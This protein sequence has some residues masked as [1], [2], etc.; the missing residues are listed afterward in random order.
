MWPKQTKR[1]ILVAKELKFVKSLAGNDPKLRR[2]VLK[3]LKIWLATRSRSTF[4]FS[5]TD[6]LRLWK[7]LFYCMWMSD[8][9]LIQENLADEIACLVKCFDDLSV[10][11]QYFGTFLETM[12]IEWFGI[13][14]W[15]MDKFMMLVRRCSRQMFTVLHEANWPTH[16]V[17][18]LMKHIENTVLNID[19]C[20]FGL[21]KHFND[22]FLEELAKV[23]EGDIDS[24]VVHLIVQ[25]YAVRLL[26]TNDMRLIKHITSSIFHSLLYQ[27]ELG[28]DYQEKF[29]L[30]KK[31]NFVTGNIDDV[32]FEVQYEYE[33]D[34][35][36]ADDSEEKSKVYD[37]RAGQVDVVINE[38]K[39]DPLKIAEI[40]ESH[41]F[42]P[43]VTSKGKKQMKMLVKQY[44]KMA[45][46]IFPLGIQ[47]VA[48]ISKKDY[49]VNIDEQV[50]ELESY[51][52][53]LVGE[54]ESNKQKR[55]KQKSIDNEK[56]TASNVWTESDESQQK[57]F[58]K[59]NE[60][61]K[62]KKKKKKLTRTQLKEEKL[63]QLKLKREVKLKALKVKKLVAAEPATNV[64]DLKSQSCTESENAIK[65]P[66][67]QANSSRGT[68]IVDDEWS[69]P[70]KD[71]ETEL[72]IP[73]R[74]TKLK[75]INKQYKVQNEQIQ[76]S[77]KLKL[78]RNPFSTP[79]NAAKS[80]KRALES[81]HI[82]DLAAK[83]KRVKIALNKNIS[84]DLQQHIQQ[85]KSSPQLP[86]DSSK[87]PSK[88]VLK[89][90]LMPS[91]I[92][93]F[94]RKRIGLKFNDTL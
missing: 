25:T 21:T 37:P 2:K 11:I 29:N 4:A 84:Q 67:S 50:E 49:D 39:F 60:S 57:H 90:N 46:G 80:L 62:A 77:Q 47:S 69:E 48:S 85:V 72:F 64:P 75:E 6:F 26:S 41:R 73:S 8:K 10:A 51:Q 18:A 59:V 87:K 3:N 15:R 81:P 1:S 86:Y 19:K 43:F 12:C 56:V 93:P 9:P 30:W 33:N 83:K 52:K 54:K 7:G 14:V 31:M 76:G 44:K 61:T 28:Q 91:P 66:S 70:L 94:Y 53:E 58:Q 74:K 36:D 88:G 20:P 16:H 34:A 5:D 40:F 92:N 17:Q 23:S 63:K 22:L 35:I 24:S 82:D 55:T 89:P 68:F 79:K 38:I 42:K 13:D 27:S 45:T 71:G 78:G 65:T 32:D